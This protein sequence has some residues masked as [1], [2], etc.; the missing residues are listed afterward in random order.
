MLEVRDLCIEFDTEDGR[1]R[2]VEGVGFE[3]REGETLAL[4]GESGCGKSVTSLAI[5]GLVPRPPGRI[6]AGEVVYG[7]RDLLRLP[8]HELH[9]IRGNEISMI[10]QE[11][12][13][14]LNPVFTIGD[15]IGE[16]ARLH[17]GQGRREALA[18]AREML[19]LVQV[20][21]PERV[22]R[23]YPHQLSGGMQQRAMI[24]MA[25]CCNP[26]LLI[27]D[28]PTTAL[29]VTTQAQILDLMRRLQDELG[30]AIL[31]ITHDLGVVAEIADRVV[32]MY[33]GR[34]VEE[35]P[36]AD[37]LAGPRMPY[38]AGLLR[39]IP[40]LDQAAL[41]RGARLESIPGTV[42]DALS[43]IVGCAFQ[44]RCRHATDLCR[45]E[46]P[47]LTTTAD[48]RAVRCHHW[49][50]LRLAASTAPA[51]GSDHGAGNGEAGA[52]PAATELL[53]VE[54]LVT[55]FPLRGGLLHRVV[56]SV[57][58]VRGVSFEI[59][60]GEVL[61][62]VGESGSGK[63]T[64]GRS[65]LRLI[66]PTEGRVTFA[67]QE[68]TG[69]PAAALKRLRR[70]MQIVFQDPYGSLNPRMTVQEILS[71]PL[72]IHGLAQGSRRSGL[73]ADLLER[74]GLS[75]DHAGRFPH[76]FSGG[77]R[78]RIAIA[79]ALAVQPSFLVAD[80]P[81][82]ALDVS[83]QAQIL[84]LLRDL[85]SGLGLTVLFIAHDLS[86]VAYLAH[87]VA[88]MYLGRIVEIGPTRSIY[89]NPAH[90]Y[91]EALLS[92]APVPDP[93]RR[94]QRMIL[95]GDIPKPSAPPSGCV[96]RTRCPI[97]VPE[98]AAIVPPLEEVAPGHLK[99]CIRR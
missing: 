81:V 40:Q 35:G 25:L 56:G 99:A 27:A 57:A 79:R 11:P 31:F 73:V 95:T 67:G 26:R 7:G 49:R 63:T 24:A 14:S 90:P 83:V 96:F 8:R 1:A 3:I 45:R 85:T 2:A 65:I 54:G 4:V 66:E 13:T 77:Q 20:P 52:A 94:R 46:E 23:A 28:E 17:R 5:I 98:C 33:A 70:E 34:V 21:D 68:L 91:T 62:L 88:V 16:A 41:Q 51:P 76:E 48:D 12:M 18:T 19:D 47:A 61:G 60:K 82:S 97:A 75:P 93:G 89:V 32:V 80:E 78:Q 39:S 50:D 58:A 42:P 43:P 71:E 59:R 22:A 30:T 6:T 64:L 55:A 29:D 44:A 37:I 74:V 38:T 53:R 36:V 72:A 92:A 9:R 87:R 10:F 86:V 15:Q 84:N 69:M